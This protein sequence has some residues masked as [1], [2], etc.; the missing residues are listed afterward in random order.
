MNNEMNVESSKSDNF[1][2]NGNEG[3]YWSDYNGT[4][5]NQDGIGDTAYIIN[6]ANQD[7]N[8]L[9]APIKSF[10]A[11]TWEWTNYDVNII[12]NSTVSNFSFDP[13][14]VQ[15]RFNVE[16][17][18][19]TTGFCRVSVPKDLLY[20]ESNWEVLANG[21]SLSPMINEDTNN[22]YLYF[23]YQHS[24]QTIEIIGTTAIPEFP[25]WT[26]MLIMLIVLA[27]AVAI[28]KRRLRPQTN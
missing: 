16:A 20:A 13:E 15:I 7:N 14:S 21:N 9:M 2:D 17:Q 8:P 12:S 24:S 11:G 23:I 26:P 28:Y 1:W 5:N 10:D 27:V 19:G 22:T 25:S 3:N 18:T 4:D 6:E